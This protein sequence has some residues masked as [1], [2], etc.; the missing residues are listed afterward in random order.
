MV[1]VIVVAIAV[2]V[3]VVAIVVVVVV[4]FL[5]SFDV[6]CCV[7]SSGQ[8]GEDIEAH[9]M[10]TQTHRRCNISAFDVLV[11]VV[12]VVSSV[13]GSTHETIVV[14]FTGTSPRAN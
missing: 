13:E 12:M 10:H 5:L 8:S 1:A 11:V 9:R 3:F 14:V 4:Q 7:V 2:A 6:V